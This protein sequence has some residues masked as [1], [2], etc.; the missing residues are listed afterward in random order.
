MKNPNIPMQAN[1]KPNVLVV[2]DEAN[3]RRLLQMI[4]E[5]SGHFEV[6]IDDSGNSAISRISEG[7]RPDVIL[8]DIHMLDGSG[9]ELYEWCSENRP[10]LADR[11]LFMTAHEK[12]HGAFV[13]EMLRAG[14][15]FRKPL[16]IDCVRG[17]ISE[18]LDEVNS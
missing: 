11:M 15:L 2:D 8:S 12:N 5:Q 3:L 14:R 13:D 7:Y 16:D 6:N 17:K 10:D 18:L 9:P 4:F 1:G